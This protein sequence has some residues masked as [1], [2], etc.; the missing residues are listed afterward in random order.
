MEKQIA[1]IAKVIGSPGCGKTT[2]LYHL[3]GEACKKYDPERIGAV[4]HTKNA[5]E[6]IKDRII[7]K[8][9]IPIE[10]LSHA[11]TIHGQCFHLLELKKGQVA[12]TTSKIK[13]FN[14]QY[15]QWELPFEVRGSED[16]D[17]VESMIDRYRKIDNKKKFIKMQILR[18][19]LIPVDTWPI[20]IKALYRDWIEFLDA[21]AYYDYTKMLEEVYIRRLAPM[22]DILF[23]DESQDLTRLQLNILLMWSEDTINTT[24]CGDANQAIFRFAGA[25]SSVFKNLE[26][27]W[28]N[29]LKQSWRV[30][31]RVKDYAM[32]VLRQANDREEVE[33]LPTEREGN[34]VRCGVP[35]LSLPGSHM[36]ITRCNRHL[37][38]WKK[39]L[40]E[41]G[42]LWHNPYR[43]DKSYNPCAAKSW[44]ALNIYLKLKDKE[45]ITLSE[46]NKLIDQLYARK[47]LKKG[48]KERYKR[49]EITIPLPESKKMGLDYLMSTGIFTPD[50]IN[51]K[52]P[53]WDK[54]NLTKQQ[55][56]IISLI[57]EKEVKDPKK[58]IIGTI[59]SVKGGEADNVW[60]DLS[61]SIIALK[62]MQTDIKAYNDEIKV[63]Y[64]ACTRARNT[65]G[66]MTAQGFNNYIFI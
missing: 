22:I 29:N 63:A 5:V 44:K 23:V 6:E 10:L 26:H 58:A 45:D 54:I 20:E 15:P 11:K 1:K 12:E 60:V 3:I 56:K 16:D 35:D 50:F 27:Q 47:C 13:E 9:D 43:N 62:E 40:L 36:I 25:E 42:W 21:N 64:V 14:E 17:L 37:L 61:T 8:T 59:H 57:G 4:S 31:K 66:L 48:F 24:F 52:I 30:P 38:K 55:E 65:L 18:N 2:Y 49:K 19:Q 28:F 46:L 53:L 7:K 33:Y 41:S 34:V 39:L 51:F 32:R